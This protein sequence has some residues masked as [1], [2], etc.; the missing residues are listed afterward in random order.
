MPTRCLRWMD[1]LS[2]VH[3][4]RDGSARVSS[5]AGVPV[6]AED[7]MDTQ[8]RNSYSLHVLVPGVSP[9]A[10]LHVSVCLASGG[11]LATVSLHLPSKMKTEIV[12]FRVSKADHM[13]HSR[14]TKR[15]SFW[16]EAV[17]S[18]GRAGAGARAPD[19]FKVCGGAAARDCR[20]QLQAR[21]QGRSH[22][23]LL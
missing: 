23:V 8:W 22:R 12:S 21:S 11:A 3:D 19:H 7:R 5:L 10:S 15:P 1:V 9:S 16:E 18:H 14:K 17:G 6:N 4:G 2:L 20:C 13:S